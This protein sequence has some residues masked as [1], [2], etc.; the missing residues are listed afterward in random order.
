MRFI[1]IRVLAVVAGSLGLCA[2]ASASEPGFYVGGFYGDSSKEF[3]IQ[4]FVDITDFV[5]GEL[6]DFVPDER[7]YSTKSEGGSYGF[8]AGYRLT[9]YI[10]FEG[11]YMYLGKESYR[12][13][14]LG[15]SGANDESWYI[16]LTR[17]TSGF[18]ISALAVL[19]IS[20]S[21]EVYARGGVM[22]AS[23]AMSLYVNGPFEDGTEFTD[24]ST[25]Y[26]AG[27]G[28][29]MSLAEVY[30]LRAEFTRIFAAG[31]D[32]FGEADVDM[33]SIGVTVA[34]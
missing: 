4:P 34:F 2:V 5:Y 21:W 1:G 12:E 14:A 17:K 10:A 8:L 3:D 27:A 23:N 7:H 28:V 31:S 13:N 20:Y 16:S 9:Q 29:S 15:T 19:P 6:L 24:S 33:I 25:D 30:A 11:G 18:A 22:F 26:L 32:D